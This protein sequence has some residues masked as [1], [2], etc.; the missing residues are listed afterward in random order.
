MEP[1]LNACYIGV[2]AVL[3][4][5]GKITGDLTREEQIQWLKQQKEQER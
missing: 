5:N 2:K 4:I 3:V 1:S